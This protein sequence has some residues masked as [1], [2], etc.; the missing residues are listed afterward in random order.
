MHFLISFVGRII[1]RQG[2]DVLQCPNCI[3]QGKNAKTMCENDTKMKPC[4]EIQP[5]CAQI[6]AHNVVQ[7]LCVSEIEFN[8]FK[9]S[10]ETDNSCQVFKI[11][12]QQ[13]FS[14]FF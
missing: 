14:T 1:S 5:A 4:K 9:A 2:D 10:C 13:V 8:N 11:S 6:N 7:R 12:P 3:G